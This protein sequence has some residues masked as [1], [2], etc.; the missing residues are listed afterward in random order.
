MKERPGFCSRKGGVTHISSRRPIKGRF[1]PHPTT[2]EILADSISRKMDRAER[3][4][5]A[6]TK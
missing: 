3:K 5:L 6:R 1:T 4:N 2:S